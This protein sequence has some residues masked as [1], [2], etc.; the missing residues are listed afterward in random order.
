MKRHNII[1]TVL[2]CGFIG[3]MA[4]LTL[5]LPKQEVSVNEK[6]VLAKPPQFSI[7]KVTSGKW[8]R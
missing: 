4:A 5:L 2:F 7:D 1:I 6:R 8:E 3:I